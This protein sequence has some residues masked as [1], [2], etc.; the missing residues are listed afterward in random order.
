MFDSVTDLSS[1]S[2]LPLSLLL[3]SCDRCHHCHSAIEVF[4]EVA[5]AVAPRGISMGK[6]D[7]EANKDVKT[8]FV[9]VCMYVCVCVCVCVLS[10]VL[11]INLVTV[12]Q[13]LLL[14][15]LKISNIQCDFIFGVQT[16]L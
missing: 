12:K 16:V 6:L 9:S 8:R 3:V 10:Q 7:I 15:L 11:F 14:A 1:F 2:L 13:L 4:Q 5:V